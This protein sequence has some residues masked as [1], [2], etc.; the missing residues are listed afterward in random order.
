[1]RVV[2]ADLVTPEFHGRKPVTE[3]PLSLDCL[4]QALVRNQDLLTDFA[5]LPPASACEKAL[6]RGEVLRTLGLAQRF[7]VR[8]ARILG[9]DMMNYLQAPELFLLL[10]L[11]GIPLR[12][13]ER[14][15]GDPL[16]VLGGHVWPNP[17]PLSDFVDVLVVGEG[18]EVLQRIAAATLAHVGGR[19][20]LL[21][22]LAQIPGAYVPAFP[23]LPLQRQQIPFARER[24]VAGSTILRDG[25]GA[26]LMARG[27]PH[28]CAFCNAGLVGGAYRTKPF[29]QLA[30]HVQDLAAAGAQRVVLVSTVVSRWRHGQHGIGDVLTAVREKGLTVRCLSDR[31]DA[32]GRRF[33]QQALH[34]SGKAILAPEASPRIRSLVLGKHISE[35]A[36]QRGI[37]E[38]ASSGVRRLQLYCVLAVPPIRPGLVPHLPDGFDGERDEDLAYLAQLAVSALERMEEAGQATE[39]PQV[40]LDCMPLIP[41][42]GTALQSLPFPSFPAYLAAVRRLRALIP[43]RWR[44]RVRIVPALDPQSHLLQALLER[45]DASRGRIVLRA[46]QRS[47]GRPPSLVQLIDA[48]AVAGLDQAALQREIPAEKLPYHDMVAFSCAEV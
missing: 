2:L 9:V 25:V 27:C 37:A 10:R 31:A 23:Q 12:W 15:A 32:S 14:G 40:K 34:Q 11:S 43:L 44:E 5:F 17:L 30:A 1:M 3:F 39:P 35:L 41:A 20:A 33:L 13:S 18:E 8:Q 29:P 21:E 4:A 22:R 45:G 36:L 46:C 26:L 19:R 7:E 38:V 28:G 16:V 42:L 47:P 24:Y 48:M 6:A